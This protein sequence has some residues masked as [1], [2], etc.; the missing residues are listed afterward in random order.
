[1][2][3][4]DAI[5]EAASLGITLRVV[6]DAIHFW[7]ASAATPEFVARLR[8]AKPHLLRY[9]RSDDPGLL[10]HEVHGLLGWASA[11]AEE[12]IVLNTPIRYLEKR[13]RPV[14]TAR[15]SHYARHYLR[16]I[17]FARLHREAGCWD[18]WSD[19]WWR[20]RELDAVEALRGLRA[21]MG[22]HDD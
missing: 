9:L 20:A 2:N 6:G 18:P 22:A 12:E 7:P 16:S 8:Q 4:T 13:L 1:M 14:T 15:V 5:E 3:P 17:G 11:L 10:P 21:A 19:D